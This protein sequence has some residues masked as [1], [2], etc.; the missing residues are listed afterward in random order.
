MTPILQVILQS[1]NKS[2][3]VL[4][5][6]RCV[7]FSPVLWALA[8]FVR[9]AFLPCRC[10]VLFFLSLHGFDKSC[11]EKHRQQVTKKRSEN[12]PSVKESD[13]PLVAVPDLSYPVPRLLQ[14][15]WMPNKLSQWASALWRGIPIPSSYPV[16]SRCV[17]KRFWCSFS[18]SNTSNISPPIQ[19]THFV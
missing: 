9:V 1:L 7:T 16:F 17:L 14:R 18:D 4:N 5:N 19:P 8:W 12:D 6:H 10:V 11:E 13:S 2:Q 15:L 3:C